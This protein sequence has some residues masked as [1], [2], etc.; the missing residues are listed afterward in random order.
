MAES[1]FAICPTR[2]RGPGN[3][4][5]N[6]W[7][8]LNRSYGISERFHQENAVFAPQVWLQK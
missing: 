3:P 4:K 6:F 8:V 7:E 2:R 1:E 5:S